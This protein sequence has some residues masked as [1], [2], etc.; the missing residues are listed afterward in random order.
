MS[1]TLPQEQS[2][3]QTDD[4]NTNFVKAEKPDP[5]HV[6]E[7]HPEKEEKTVSENLKKEHQEPSNLDFQFF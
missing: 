1:T 6:Q 7:K 3:I 5:V 2:H 4:P